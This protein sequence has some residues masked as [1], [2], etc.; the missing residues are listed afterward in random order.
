[1]FNKF[2]HLIK[3]INKSN[4]VFILLFYLVFAFY[5]LFVFSNVIK[6]ITDD[7]YTQYSSQ[8]NFLAFGRD[9]DNLDAKWSKIEDIESTKKAY[10]ASNYN[11]LYFPIDLSYILLY[12][13]FGMCLIFRLNKRFKKNKSVTKLLAILSILLISIGMFDLIENTA[14][15]VYLNTDAYKSMYINFIANKVKLSSTIIIGSVLLILCTLNFV[16]DIRRFYKII[17]I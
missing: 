11:L 1:M 13:I 7:N 2:Y 5:P 9:N 12:S 4:F 8:S 3:L 10:D 6:I 15:L 16:I 17:R 14:L